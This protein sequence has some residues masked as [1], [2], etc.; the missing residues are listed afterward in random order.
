MSFN[1]LSKSDVSDADF[2]DASELIS[3]GYG[4]NSIYLSTTCVSTNSSKTIIIN[5]PSDGEGILNSFNHPGQTGD[6]VYVYGTSGGLGDGY[7]TINTVTDNTTITVN[8][9]IGTSTGGNIQF[10]YPA[11]ASQIGYNSNNND[12]IKY[13]TVQNALYDLDKNSLD[14]IKHARVRQLVHLANKDDAGGPFE[15]F[16]GAYSELVYA[17]NSP[18]YNGRIWYTDN[19]KQYKIVENIIVRNSINMPT[20]ITW[21]VYDLDG[22]TVL[23]T[24]TDSIVYINN[25]FETSRTRTIS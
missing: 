5:L 4:S 24:V 9:S 19:T 16:A 17:G 18:F 2:V 25:I 11:G 23:S 3:D 12:I 7:F 21:K 1:R 10:R 8:E 6:I 13:N 22:I 20:T 14:S 15:G